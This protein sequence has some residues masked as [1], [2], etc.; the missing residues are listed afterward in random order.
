M[1]LAAP[2]NA[3]LDDRGWTSRPMTLVQTA[4]LAPILAAPARTDLPPVDL[5]DSG[6]DDWY[7]MVADHKGGLPAAARTI[8]NGVPD[9]VFAHVRDTDGE[10]L[11]VA[12]GA[13]S[14]PDRWLG[15]SLVQTTP[16]A[17]RRGLG[18]HVVRGLAHWA[19]QRGANRAYLQVEERNT[20]AVALYGRLGFSTH[21]TYLTRE[22][23]H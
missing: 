20:P 5:A 4:S 1:P 13:V 3:A 21:H 11:A 19:S 22:A 23:P 6:G 8:L 2:V 17:R 15:V 14:G 12:R 18:G 16:A 10:L 7:A 9:R